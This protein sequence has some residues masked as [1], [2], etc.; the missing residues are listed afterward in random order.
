[1]SP[2]V[3]DWQRVA[4]AFPP[5]VAALIVALV[6]LYAWQRFRPTA[7]TVAF[8]AYLLGVL[9]WTAGYSLE[10]LAETLSTKQLWSQ[11]EYV[12][13]VSTPVM[14]LLFVLGYTGHGR[15][16]TR[17]SV[18]ALLIVP[19]TTLAMVW[20]NGWHHLFWQDLALDADL[21]PV[22]ILTVTYGPWFAVHTAYSYILLLIALFPLIQRAI[23]TPGFYRWQAIVLI[24]ASSVPSLANALAV[25]VPNLFPG[26]DLTPFGFAVA[27][28]LV[29]WAV[30]GFRLMIEIVSAARDVVIENLPDAVIVLD[31]QHRVV[32][33]NPAGARLLSRPRA[34]LIGL[35]SDQVFARWSELVEQYRDVAEAHIEVSIDGGPEPR[36]LEVNVVPLRDRRGG[37][38]GR[39]VTARDITERQ[40]ANIALREQR[41][42]AEA[43]RDT[44]AALNSSLDLD[45]VLD[46][47][48]NSVGRVVAHD[49]AN[50]TLVEDGRTAR[51]ARA[52]GYEEHGSPSS[53]VRI[54][55]VIEGLAGF[56]QMLRTRQPAVISDVSQHA[57]WI[58]L[59][60]SSW[61]QSSVG[62]PILLD[63]EMIGFLS[64]DSAT[65]GFFSEVHAERLKAFA[66]QVAMAIKNARL[67]GQSEDR[68]QKLMLLNLITRIGTATL[69]LNEL[70]QTLAD[71][72][73]LI[74]GGDGCYITLWDSEKRQAAPGAAS[75]PMRDTYR[76]AVRAE[77]GEVTL[78][79]SVL[80]AGAPL[81]IEDVLNTPYVSRHIAERYPARSMLALPLH[82]AGRD[83]GALLLAF[84]QTHH[85]TEEEIVWAEQAAELITLALA[86]AQA[87]A[88]IQ[89][90]NRELDAYS[91]TVAH[92]LKSP[93]HGITGY[94]G[95]L[96]DDERDRLTAEGQAMLDRA[97][98]YAQKMNQIIEGLL[99]MASLR[100][101][102]LILDS[103]DMSS[104]VQAAVERL[105]PEIERRGVKIG[106]LPGLPPVLGFA[107]WLEEVFANLISNAIKYIGPDNPDPCISIRGNPH[108][109]MVR[110][111]VLDNGVGIEPEDQARLFE[112][113]SRFHRDLAHGAG[114]GLSIV[115]RIITRLNGT[116]G[117]ESVLGQGST[118]WFTLPAAG[119]DS[120]PPQNSP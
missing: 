75:G 96:S 16:V 98:E 64:L 8:V 70:L 104:V 21:A 54:D 7:G 110:Y 103:V 48:L 53:L 87:Y 22:P 4:Y 106:I 108:E 109:G 58:R 117:V 60:I 26:L 19:A 62:A 31:A 69:D 119:R 85:F 67:Y 120:S 113:F 55:F 107:P 73:A 17:F 47:I 46:L 80:Q 12:G 74:I 57:D 37:L 100:A 27:G 30:F 102:D 32:D 84:N 50:I 68:T 51:V 112:T 99:L 56:S 9:V 2:M 25:G 39:I 11:I 44:A 29:V 43:L 6:A 93:L 88:E 42:L 83:L 41:V 34:E 79:Q 36:C 77:P 40:R 114:L 95:L 24:V 63:G 49:A 72:A 14:W 15:W 115:Q 78:T 45:E 94:L 81:A 33:I 118:F 101:P 35:P 89:D 66:D 61:I 91:H 10:I 5:A 82:T 65:P 76:E 111:E 1:M 52:R 38:R 59:P 92:D 105:R 90:R 18:M 13:I 97:I 23:W 3:F 116:V 86:R 28:L 71:T 20:T